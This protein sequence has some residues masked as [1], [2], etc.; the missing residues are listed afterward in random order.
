M[1]KG[2][3]TTV[4]VTNPPSKVFLAV[5][6][7]LMLLLLLLT[8]ATATLQESVEW[9]CSKVSCNM[10]AV[11]PA[12]PTMAI[13]KNKGEV[14]TAW[15]AILSPEYSQYEPQALNNTNAAQDGCV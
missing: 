15:C 4:Q 10:L 1:A 11:C 14:M 6:L 13:T 9:L 12:A 3:D 7:L 8:M 5:A 2:F